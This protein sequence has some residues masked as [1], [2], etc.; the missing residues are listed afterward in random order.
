MSRYPVGDI[1]PAQQDQ[2]S[3]ECADSRELLQRVES[4]FMAERGETIRVEPPIECRAA[5]A[6][7]SLPFDARQ[8]IQ[9]LAIGQLLGRR[10]AAIR[11]PC[12]EKWSPASCAT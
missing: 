7:Q 2:F 5:E 10:K 3:G 12:S 8:A 9:T 4:L 6:D 1:D 11:E